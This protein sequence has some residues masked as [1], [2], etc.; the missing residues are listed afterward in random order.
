[1]K[2]RHQIIDKGITVLDTTI[3]CRT[4][5]TGMHALLSL[6]GRKYDPAK[7]QRRRDWLNFYDGDDVLFRVMSE[8]KFG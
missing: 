3:Q 8:R 7:L 6:H 4:E 5:Y 2:V 1:M